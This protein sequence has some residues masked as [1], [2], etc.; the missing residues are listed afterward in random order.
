LRELSA[1]LAAGKIRLD[2][3]HWECS[4]FAIAQHG[5]ERAGAGHGASLSESCEAASG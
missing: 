4:V 2:R 1:R 3:K 5:A